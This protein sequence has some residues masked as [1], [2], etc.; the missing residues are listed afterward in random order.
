MQKLNVL[1]IINPVAG[2]RKARYAAFQI[3]DM[4]TRNG[5]KTTVFTTSQKGDAVE[6]VKAFGGEAQRIICCGGDGTLNEVITGLALADL[7]VPVGYIPTGTTN[8]LAHA[9]NLP[10]KIDKA[11]Y[12]ALG[13]GMRGYDIGKFNDNQYFSYVSSFGAFS[14][15]SYG[16]PQLIK[17]MFGRVSYLINGVLRIGDIRP[18]KV[19]VVADEREIEG[20]F[21]FGSIS[22]STI[23]GGT[24]RLPEADI[25]FDDGKFEVTL[26][27]NPTSPK[28]FRDGLYGIL[29]QQ[30]KEE[31]HIYFFKARKITLTFEEST[32]WSIDG[33]CAGVHETVTIENLKCATEII[34][35]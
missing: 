4:L 11:I 32:E 14:N 3:I 20:E 10:T 26:I 16:T 27:K 1:L 31:Q 22:N 7:H 33:E 21:I 28:E 18:H 6:Y 2:R 25:E 35:K 24:L 23:I 29:A 34:A 19:K 12:V 30:Y 15:A 9:L 13:D 5:C 17:N 8:D